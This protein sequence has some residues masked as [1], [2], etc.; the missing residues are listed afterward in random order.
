VQRS[1]LQQLGDDGQ[2][3]LLAELSRFAEA[4]DN[5]PG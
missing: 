4:I 5:W 2:N 1:R 3:R